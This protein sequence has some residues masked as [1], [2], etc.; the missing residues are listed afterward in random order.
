MIA[1]AS[2]GIDTFACCGCFAFKGLQV[3]GQF[4]YIV[5][6]LNS[7]KLDFG[8]WIDG[9]DGGEKKKLEKLGRM[10]RNGSCEFFL[11]VLIAVLQWVSEQ[12]L[13]KKKK[14]AVEEGNVNNAIQ[15]GVNFETLSF[16]TLFIAPSEKQLGF[17][18]VFDGQLEM[19]KMFVTSIVFFSN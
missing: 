9:C 18:C 17:S 13:K 1:Y 15:N 4:A 12:F 8:G 2:K 11:K 10:L 16:Y 7:A 14:N 3:W 19:V 5:F 6:S